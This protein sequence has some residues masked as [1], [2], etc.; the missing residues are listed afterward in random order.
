MDVDYRATLVAG[1]SLAITSDEVDDV[2]EKAPV[3]NP[4]IWFTKLFSAKARHRYLPDEPVFSQGEPADAVFYVQRGKVCLTVESADGEQVVISV[5][6]EGSFLGECCLAGQA[7]RSV[8]AS[9]LLRST[10][11]RIE[12]QSMMDLLHSDPEFAERFFTYTLSRSIRMEADLIDHFFDS[13]DECLVR[14]IIKTNPISEW[15]PIPVTT[16]ISPES[17][18]AMIGTTSS[19]VSLF[20][21]R[22]RAL[23]FIDFK[24]AKML[25][26]GSLMGIMP[27]AEGVC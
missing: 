25:V 17:L 3:L 6:G 23:G 13:G 26:N 21:E 20:L 14:Q 8:T 24:G 2:Q 9:T 7:V 1:K 10:V 19:N 27:D 16:K 4:C 22:F 12:K 11:V 5:L 15:K 18:A